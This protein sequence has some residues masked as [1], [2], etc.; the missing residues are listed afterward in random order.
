MVWRRLLPDATICDPHYPL[1]RY[2]DLHADVVWFRGYQPVDELEIMAQADQMGRPFRVVQKAVVKT[3]AVA[4]AVPGLIKGNTR[5]DNQ[6][7]FV[8][9]V[10]RTGGAGFQNAKAAFA[11]AFDSLDL[12]EDHVSAADRRIENA[13]TG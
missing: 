1:I 10:I 13:L 2:D 7:R 12:T 6:V 3:L 9:L 8:G 11:Q 4:D 5:Y